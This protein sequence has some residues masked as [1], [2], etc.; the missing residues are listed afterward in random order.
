LLVNLGFEK[1]YEGAIDFKFDFK[2]E[3]N[4]LDII[5]KLSKFKIKDKA[6]DFIGSRMGRPEKAKL[7]KLIGSPNVLFPV[8]SEG[9]RLRS[10][11]QA[12]EVGTVKSNFP[13]YYCEE[14]K[15]ET[16]YKLCE[17]CGKK[18]IEK[19]YCK[20]CAREIEGKKCSVH[21]LG[22][23]FKD[24]R[25]DMKHYFNKAREALG[26]NRSEI[27]VLIKGVKGTSSG[28][29]DIENLA[30][31][32]LRVKHNLCVNKDGTIRYDMTELPLSHFKPCEIE[33]GIEKLKE[34][35]YTKDCFGKELKEETQILELKPH[36]I[37]LPC[38]VPCGDE[39]A[40]DVFINVAKFIDEMLVKLYKLPPFYN[41]KKREDLVGVLGV[42]MAPHNCAGAI[43]RIIG[44]SKVQGLLASPYMHAAM[45]RD[46]DG[47]EAALML[48]ADVLI[49][50][51]RKFLPAHRGGTQDAPLVLNGK[52]FAREVD[53]QILDF[54]LVNNY[55][56]DIYEKAEQ[57]LHS[58]Q[59][60]IEMV[61]QRLKKDGDPYV[62]TGFT[63]DTTNFNQGATCSS[64]KTLPTMKDK[65][66]AQM[67]LCVKLRSV[68]Q[69]DVA[70]LIIDRHLM[71]DLK[72]NLRKFSQQA[73]R[74]S[75]CNESYR[76]PPLAGK[77]GKCGGRI[78][79]TIAYGSIVKYMEH[80]LSLTRNY[81]VPDYIKQDLELTKKYI[82]SIFGKDNEKQEDLKKW[83]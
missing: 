53:D 75:S 63:H 72:G 45:R 69:G 11:N 57:R 16:I 65:V 2:T 3:N 62:N 61:K 70:R 21:D 41:V 33:V 9:G 59:V 17:G 34:L 60:E 29:H 80:A 81:N 48:L 38:N 22:T 76:R 31:G 66:T 78:I 13:F 68:D 74:C 46:C 6:G 51:S 14:C 39:R 10:V 24:T 56:L 64:Y 67:D 8:G 47:D 79:F 28:N 43:C 52:I 30:K 12:A 49:N 26:L 20:L 44:F 7:R 71:R 32:M 55:P 1:N 27:Q 4:V 15:R 35:G 77:C 36:D 5:N 58:S 83:F 50:F 18:T 40:D 37:L 19:Y 23:T 73:F 42:C 54:E 25:I 82:E